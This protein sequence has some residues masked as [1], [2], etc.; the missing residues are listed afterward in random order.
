MDESPVPR[1]GLKKMLRV[2]AILSIILAV[3]VGA[4]GA[5]LLYTGSG[6]EWAV[7]RIRQAAGPALVLEGMSGTLSGGMTVRRAHF[8]LDDGTTVEARELVLRLSPASLLKLAPRVI[9][10]RC[11]DLVITPST[12]KTPSK[13]PASLALP[14]EIQVASARIARLRITGAASAFE[15]ENIEFG[16]SGGG[17]GHSLH[18]AS[19]DFYGIHLVGSGTIGSGRPFTVNASLTA[20]RDEAPAGKL[21]VSIAGPLE[22]LRLQAHADAAGGS[23]DAE[24]TLSPYEPV[25]L[26]KLLATAS[27]LDLQA[28]DP[29]LPRTALDAKMILDPVRG[30]TRG[31][32]KGRLDVRNRLAG[33][34]DKER[35]PL[36]ALET[37]VETD[38]SRARLNGR[39]DLGTAG[40]LTGNAEIS[41]QGATLALRTD[42]LDLAGLHSRMRAT[43]LSGRIDARID[44]KKQSATADLSERDIQ[45]AFQLEKIGDAVELRDVRARARGGEARGTGRVVLSAAR[46]FN[47]EARLTAFNPAAWGDF[48]IGAVNGRLTAKGSLGRET[49]VD[50][51]FALDTSQLR[52]AALTGN[53]HF[54]L[55]GERVTAAQSDLDW[56]GNRLSARGAWGAPGDVLTVKVEAPRLAVVNPDWSGRATANAELAGTRQ[57]PSAK[58][59]VAG[60]NLAWVKRGRIEALSARGE[61]SSRPDGPLR[62]NAA[63]TGA[64]AQDL[65]ITSAGLDVDGTRQAHVL[66]LRAQ[67]GTL[68]LSGR[69]RGGWQPAGNWSGT[70]EALENRGEYP[71]A[72]EAPVTLEVAPR[73]LRAGKLAMRVAGG[74]LDANEIRYDEGRIASQGQFS[75]LRARVLLALAGLSPEAGGT[76]Q[77]A[78]SWALASEPRW[79]GTVSIR[80]QSGDLSLAPKEAMPLGLETLTLDARIVDDRVN[81]RGALRARVATGDIDGSISPVAG[82]QGPRF[83]ADS[84]VKFSSSLDIARLA[85][86]TSSPDLLLRLDG[87]VKAAVNGSGTVGDPQ[88]SGTVEGDDIAIAVAQEGVSLKN[89]ALRAELAGREVRVRSFSIRG[90]AGSFKA[91]GTL[92]RGETGRAALDWEAEKLAVMERPGRR[93]IVTGRGKAALDEGKVS[94]SGELKADEGEIELRRGTLV[95]PGDDVVVTGRERA[96][97]ETPRLRQAALDLALDF[98]DRFRISGRGLNTFLAGSIRVQTGTTG[99]LVA[100]GTVNTV[101]GTYTAFSQKLDLERGRLIFEGPIDNPTLDIRAMRKMP[102]VEAGVEVA[103]TLRKPFVRVVSQPSLPQNEALSWLIL[104]HAPSDSS[105]TDLSMLPLAAAALLGQDEAT[106]T[107]VAR[108]LG[109]DSIGLRS[110]SGSTAG[111]QFVTLGKRVA[112]D[113]YVVY[114]QGFG[115]AASV[116]KLEF[117]VTRRVLLRAETGQT[118][119]LGVFYRWAFD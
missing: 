48:P 63:I 51:D 43:R 58:F 36:V 108:T 40:Q 29:A 97:T 7:T 88:L 89:G 33:S 49:V 78:G 72:L 100:K 112:D 4:T 87:R 117:N 107:G 50:A 105:G 53:G 23:A 113:L 28:L 115:A 60:N 14:L 16:Y 22:R 65:R 17:S 111:A 54:S 13:L 118:S 74:R 39:A 21:A 44:G 45:L 37:A 92:A 9:E 2:I 32:L 3:L 91:Q 102:E 73:R 66:T 42:R 86:F 96:T 38:F 81:F 103:G 99:D 93:L 20:S 109:F 94:L 98:G 35:L 46:P 95:T 25:P 75:G 80:R 83:A 116:L 77:L 26:Q 55:R 68:D 106:G 52:G 67:G 6:L 114:E 57:A 104:G 110:G 5:W 24:G 1:R 10:L 70:V 56:G 79:N 82:P 119:G 41:A 71:V 90:G 76:M 27:G 101:R 11:A 61:Y 15:A 59:T 30:A 18:N 62:L 47:A 84:P 8:A 31:E 85:A 12:T 19:I 34:Y 69:A 64:S